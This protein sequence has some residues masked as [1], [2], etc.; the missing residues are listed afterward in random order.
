MNICNAYRIYSADMEDKSIKQNF[1][2]AKAGENVFKQIL[3]KRIQ[4]ENSSKQSLA[5]SML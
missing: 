2:K 1:E 4:R 5:E 3:T